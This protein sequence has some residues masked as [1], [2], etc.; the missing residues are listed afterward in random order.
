M[1]TKA[2]YYLPEHDKSGN[3]I[4]SEAVRDY[5]LSYAARI[6]NIVT[7]VWMKL[8]NETGRSIAEVFNVYTDMEQGFIKT[9]IPVKAA[10]IN[11]EP[12]ARSQAK[13][14]CSRLET[15]KEVV[16]D[17]G[18]FPKLFYKKNYFNTSW[19]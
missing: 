12:V 4:V 7:L 11:G 9:S 5:L 14:I 15:F 18:G 13:R 16:L 19:E 17:F 3:G 1:L 2:K 8:E 10:C 6:Q